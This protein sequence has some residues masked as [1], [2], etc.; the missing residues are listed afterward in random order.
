MGRKV[1]P[2]RR[3][4]LV[5]RR[6]CWR[7]FTTFAILGSFSR[8]PLVDGT[9]KPGSSDREAALRSRGARASLVTPRA[10]LASLASM[11]AGQ[12]DRL[13][14]AE[15]LEFEGEYL[16]LAMDAERWARTDDGAA[17]RGDW[18][19]TVNYCRRHMK[20]WPPDQLR[21]A[22]KGARAA[23]DLRARAAN[24]VAWSTSLAALGGGRI[25]FCILSA[26]GEERSGGALRHCRGR[27]PLHDPSEAATR[28]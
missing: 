5:T 27:H 17:H 7:Y 18:L 24:R 28:V 21:R 6:S 10:S 23:R 1:E 22:R 8:R 4:D 19:C 14:Y 2:T 20:Q 11:G 15:R 12:A 3:L 26:I 9:P 13:T 16:E 25:R